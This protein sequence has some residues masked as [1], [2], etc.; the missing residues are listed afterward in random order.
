MIA[1]ENSVDVCARWF[2]QLKTAEAVNN[3]DTDTVKI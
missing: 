2:K 1:S 3:I